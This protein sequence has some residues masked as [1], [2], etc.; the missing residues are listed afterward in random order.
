MTTE[1]KPHPTKMTLLEVLSGL[2]CDA[3]TLELK[4]RRYVCPKCGAWMA[5]AGL[6]LPNVRKEIS[7][8]LREP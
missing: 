3:P 1:T 8:R 4:G 7:R 2:K 5:A 6:T